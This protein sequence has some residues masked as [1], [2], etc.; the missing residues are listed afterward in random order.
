MSRIYRSRFVRHQPKADRATITSDAVDGKCVE[1][2]CD[3]L[4]RFPA[5]SDLGTAEIGR[6]RYISTL[7]LRTGDAR[8]TAPR[9]RLQIGIRNSAL[10]PRIERRAGGFRSVAWGRPYP[11]QLNGAEK[12]L[13]PSF[14]KVMSNALIFDRVGLATFNV[15]FEG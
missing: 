14:L 13:L 7:W 1:R 15:L 8:K 10:W 3:V 9:L 11:A 2:D 6:C 12:A 4:G 5:P